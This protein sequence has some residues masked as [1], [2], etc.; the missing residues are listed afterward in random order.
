[1]GTSNGGCLSTHLCAACFVC[2]S[3][4]LC[5]EGCVSWGRG[6]AQ[7]SHAWSLYWILFSAN[8]FAT[9]GWRGEGSIEHTPGRLTHAKDL[10]HLGSLGTFQTNTDPGFPG[11]HRRSHSPKR[12]VKYC[13]SCLRS[14]KMKFSRH[15]RIYLRTESNET[16]IK[17]LTR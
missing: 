3:R 10:N 4:N 15:P 12:F 13:I 8:G 7:T 1:M 6:G 11:P 14:F 2:S 9:K 16:C 5:T 17:V